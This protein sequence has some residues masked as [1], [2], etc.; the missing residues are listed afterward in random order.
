MDTL[1]RGRVDVQMGMEFNFDS[2]S[3]RVALQQGVFVWDA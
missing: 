1:A 2:D 3:F